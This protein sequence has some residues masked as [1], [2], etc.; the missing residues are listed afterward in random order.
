MPM[1]WYDREL[2]GWV[3]QPNSP[4]WAYRLAHY[5]ALAS[6]VWLVF[7]YWLHGGDL[8]EIDTIGYEKEKLEDE[9]TRT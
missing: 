6:S 4:K 7:L 8:K 1:L 9:E 2:G 5:L 3:V